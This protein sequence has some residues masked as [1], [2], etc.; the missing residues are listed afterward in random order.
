MGVPMYHSAPGIP[1][2]LEIIGRS[3]CVCRHLEYDQYP[4]LHMY[5][6]AQKLR[7]QSGV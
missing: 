3:G 4:E 6:I 2:L 1:A 5:I 7:E